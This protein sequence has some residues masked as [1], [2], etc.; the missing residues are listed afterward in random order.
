MET[1]TVRSRSAAIAAL[2]VMV[3]GAVGLGKAGAPPSPARRMAEAASWVGAL[4]T[5]EQRA[6][7]AFPLDSKVRMDWHYIPRER[8]GVKFGSMSPQQLEAVHALLRSALSSRGYLK[9]T[10]I[11]Q[12]EEI[13]RDMEK[14]GGGDGKM[15][16]PG[17][18]VIAL[19][20][21]PAKDAAWGWK[22]EGHHIS[23]NFTVTGSNGG[24]GEFS[25]TPAFLGANPARVPS[26]VHAGWRILGEEEDL[27][28]A[29]LMSLNESQRKNAILEDAAPA[30]IV[31]SPGR[32]HDLTS[33]RGVRYADLDADQK[34]LLVRLIEEYVENLQH[35]MAEEQMARIRE[36][37]LDEIRF[38][39][40][41]SSEEGKGH[42]YRIHGPTFVIELDNTQNNANHVHTAWHDLERDFGTDLLKE[43]YEQDHVHGGEGHDHD[44]DH[45][46]GEAGGKQGK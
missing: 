15:R 17:N 34:A 33:P 40:A 37:G 30:D 16:D 42:Y 1:T 7:G 39:W 29:L 10:S 32:E 45:V 31:L 9:A 13:L 25:A 6:L 14:A 12:L 36:K 22:I 20:G 2:V 26:G 21:D 8:K 38:A 18:Y 43:H 11:F 27:G 3:L 41:G 44:G 35:D 28:K 5:D 23:L 46:H 19:F 24:R 4:W